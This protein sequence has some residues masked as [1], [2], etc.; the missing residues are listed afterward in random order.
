MVTVYRIKPD[1][2]RFQYFLTERDEDA[3]TLTMDCARKA[4]IWSPPSVYIYKPMLER[5][6]FY[7]F[8]SSTIISSPR[9]TGI[10]RHHY[11]MAGELLPIPY[12]D[13]TYTVLNVT[14]CVN[15]LDNEGTEWRREKLSGIRVWIENYAFHRNRFPKS[16]IF[17][18]PET[19]RSEV[20][21]TEGL[22]DPEDE[23]KFAVESAGLQGLIF[24]KLWE[25]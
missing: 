4:S 3:E 18:I 24:E 14:E 13:E 23:F 6:D 7:S 9:A 12:L 1:V 11:V 19:C 5:G 21:V 20:L 22:R 16:N 17:K 10:L 25:G 2:N 8:D 15:C